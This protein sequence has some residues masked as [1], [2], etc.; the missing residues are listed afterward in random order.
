MNICSDCTYYKPQNND[1]GVCECP[2]PVWVTPKSNRLKNKVTDSDGM[3]C[4]AF[5]V[6]AMLIKYRGI[7]E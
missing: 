3:N 4:A 1:E 7:N 2:I 5:Q 6:N